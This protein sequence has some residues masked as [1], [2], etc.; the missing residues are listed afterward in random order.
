MSN[1]TNPGHA[2][3]AG[4]TVYYLYAAPTV[5]ADLK[6][7]LE[8]LQTF[9]AQ[10]NADT[11]DY[12][13]PPVLPS[14]TKAPPPATR[15]LITAA[16]HKS[17]HASSRNQPKH[18]SAY[19]CTDASWALNPHEYGAVVHVFANN[20]DPAQGYH[21]YFMYSK[22]RQKINAQS[23]KDALAQAEANDFG[24]LGQG[25]LA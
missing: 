8:V 5:K 19:V 7:E 25:D 13:N 14:D 1:V 18:L 3:I 9:L 21:E 6:H 16:N 23:I 11:E 20:E 4:G 24:T 17:T 22:K 12:Q 2:T 10:W 15:L